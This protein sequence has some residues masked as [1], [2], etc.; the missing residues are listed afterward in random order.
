MLDLLV[1]AGVWLTL[2]GVVVALFLAEQWE[3]AKTPEM[4]RGLARLT[5]AVPLW[6]PVAIPLLIAISLAW[7]VSRT[8]HSVR[9]LWALAT[10]TQE[11][12][13]RPEEGPYR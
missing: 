8:I 12:T 10:S 11:P 1:V 7:V 13:T 5:L 3:G 4:R 2:N 6:G 9:W